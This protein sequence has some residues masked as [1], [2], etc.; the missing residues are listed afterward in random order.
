MM[1]KLITK[2]KKK[3]I[4][5]EKEKIIDWKKKEKWKIEYLH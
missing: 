4:E 5:K 1:T 2:K 3:T